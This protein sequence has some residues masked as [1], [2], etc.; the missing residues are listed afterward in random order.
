ME[1]KKK[2]NLKIQKKN[3]RMLVIKKKFFFIVYSKQGNT[4]QS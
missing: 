3:I 1:R 4:N 2:E